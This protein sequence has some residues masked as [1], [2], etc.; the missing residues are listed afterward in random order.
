MRPQQQSDA[1]DVL[2]AISL[3]QSSR[4][5]IDAGLY[6][7]GANPRIDRAIASYSDI[8]S[9]LKQS[10]FERVALETTLDQLNRL[11]GRAA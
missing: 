8:V 5:L 4:T 10:R 1:L 11:M 6:T 3:H 9:F 2:E 7:K